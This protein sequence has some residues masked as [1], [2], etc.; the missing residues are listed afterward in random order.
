M[1]RILTTALVAGL[2]VMAMAQSPSFIPT[3]TNIRLGFVYPTENA[4]RDFTGNMFGL[5]VD[6]NTNFRLI[7][8]GQGFLSLDYY[9]SSLDGNKG[10]VLTAMYNQRMPLSSMDGRNTYYF[11]GAGLVNVDYSTSKTVFGL[12]GGVG[13]T[14][15]EKTYGELVYT[16]TEKVGGARATSFGAYLG[17]KF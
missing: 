4:V 14:L 9:T 11:V 12:R 5:G 1:K 2:G 3:N 8:Y 6:I 13:M 10:R 7:S 15:S 17:F 16:F